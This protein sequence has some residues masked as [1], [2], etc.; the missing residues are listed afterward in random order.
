MYGSGNFRAE[1]VVG[2]DHSIIRI[3]GRLDRATAPVLRQC[4]DDLAEGRPAIIVVDVESLEV[5]DSTGLRLALASHNQARARGTPMVW[6]PPQPSVR[7]GLEVIRLAPRSTTTAMESAERAL[8]PESEDDSTEGVT[9][10]FEAASP[11]RD[12]DGL[13]GQD[14][15]AA[16]MDRRPPAAGW[17]PDPA[18][19]AELR[20]WDGRW[21]A[22]VRTDGR[23]S[24]SALQ[25]G[26]PP[27]AS[28]AAKHL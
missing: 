7:R 25:N 13:A 9:E 5:C 23:L 17:F 20:Y 11:G 24:L 26:H 3:S 15:D 22:H 8:T 28:G 27:P 10:R 6:R 4:F 16:D 12:E 14:L 19:R 21:T 18:G 1:V 2:D